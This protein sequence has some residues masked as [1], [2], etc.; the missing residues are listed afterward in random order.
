M[1]IRT[2]LIYILPLSLVLVL[3]ILLGLSGL[4]NRPL[5]SL[6]TFS[7][8]KEERQ[9][10]SDFFL[11]EIR[12]LD[13]LHTVEYVH[14]TVFPF[15]FLDPSINYPRLIHRLRSETGS[16]EELLSPAER[17]Y[18]Q[19]R[20]LAVRLGVDVSDSASEFVVVT[21]IARAGLDLSELQLEV[22]DDRRSLLVY[23]PP[24]RIVE[25]SLEDT[26]PEDYP[27]PDIRLNPAD[28][29]DIVA[30]I[31]DRI[32]SRL[33]EEGILEAAAAGGE[34]FL[35]AL[36]SQSGFDSLEFRPLRAPGSIDPAN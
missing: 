4:L 7:F 23:L 3:A 18:L 25:I 6:P 14:K 2:F 35:R 34:D 17:E 16:T 21:V 1:K 31:E 27:Y 32:G 13:T 33:I 29:R 28:W 24:P 15:D 5:F 30:F 12:K 20:N 36:F 10:S 26:K 22:Q 11:E 19:A 8:F 9:F